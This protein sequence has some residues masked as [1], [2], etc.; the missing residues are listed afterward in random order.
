MDGQTIGKARILDLK[1]RLRGAWLK[2][3]G[4]GDVV[5]Q[6]QHRGKD[7][8]TQLLREAIMYTEG[9]D[10]LLSVLFGIPNFYH[11]FGYVPVYPI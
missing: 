2:M 8:A 9:E 4:I 5:I 1:V 7:Y 11:R 10:H 3:G 6:R